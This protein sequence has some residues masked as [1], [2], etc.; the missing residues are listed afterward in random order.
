MSTTSSI[1][2]ISDTALWVAI[3]RARESERADAIFKDPFARKLAG[4]RGER[5][6]AEL[7]PSMRY[8]WPY[9]ARTWSFDKIINDCIREG[10]DTVINLAAGLDARPFRMELPP[11][12]RWVEVDLPDMIDYKEEILRGETPRWQLERVK[13]DLRDQAGRRELFT[14]IGAES[15]R[16][17][18]LTEGLI[19]YLEREQVTELARDLCAQESFKDWATDLSS[20]ALVKMLQKNLSA[21]GDANAP[22]IFGPEEGPDFFV[23]LGWRPVEL[24]NLLKV[25]GKLKRLPFLFRIFSFLPDSKGKKPKAV[26]GGV[27]RLSRAEV[28]P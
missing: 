24:F 25:A 26:W 7:E 18:I 1:R 6:A 28:R 5:I 12:L 22:L 9:L 4:E 11:S 14:R 15:K 23:P 8:E 21:L 17:L 13:L 3:Y 19:V 10:A 20:P 16:A 27:I 2:N